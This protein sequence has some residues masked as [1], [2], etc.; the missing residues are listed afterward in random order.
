MSP[1]C[2]ACKHCKGKGHLA[3]DCPELAENRQRQAE[4]FE[5]DNAPAD[6]LLVEE[7][8]E[9]EG[10]R[11]FNDIRMIFE[12]EEEEEEEGGNLSK[13]HDEVTGDNKPEDSR[14]ENNPDL[15]R[16]KHKIWYLTLDRA[17]HIMLCQISYP[18]LQPVLAVSYVAN[19]H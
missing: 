9:E 14:S 2:Y 11:G 4:T 6:L 17:L 3:K 7:E 5:R 18:L 1:S 10:A 8:G 13:G 19:I 12:D 16:Y 15:Q